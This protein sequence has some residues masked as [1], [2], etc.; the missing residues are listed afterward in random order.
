MAHPFSNYMN[1]DLGAEELAALVRR[2]FL[3]LQAVQ[4]ALGLVGPGILGLAVEPLPDEI[5]IH[6]AIEKNTP[7]LSEDLN[8]IIDDLEA[9]LAGGPDSDS[10]I[11]L[12]LHH[13]HPGQAWHND[14]WASFYISKPPSIPNLGMLGP[15]PSLITF[16]S[17][18][19]IHMGANTRHWVSVKTFRIDKDS[20]DEN[21]ILTALIS[22]PQY[23][24]HYAG[25]SPDNQGSHLLHGPYRLDHISVQSFRRIDPHA[26]KALLQHWAAQACADPSAAVEAGLDEWVYSELINNDLFQLQDMCPGAK[27]E[28]GWVVGA[29][30]GFHELVA[31]DRTNSRL[32][33]VVASDD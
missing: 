21:S 14:S 7:E 19:T 3:V 13:G 27:H 8:D 17:E 18:R 31:I 2:N 22:D 15:M 12:Q 23:R 32:T 20:P 25:G 5:V 28:W 1:P 10:R 4:A 29:I 26:A 11:R 30:N 24:D 9:L 6:A 33:L 16:E